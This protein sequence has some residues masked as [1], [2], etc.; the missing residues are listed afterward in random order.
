MSRE[1][2]R[3]AIAA[4]TIPLLVEH[5]SQ[6][7]TRQIALAAGVAEGTLFR[8]FDDKV[9]LLRTAAERALDPQVG[10]REI[11][12]LPQAASLADE[13]AQVARVVLDHGRRARRVMVGLHTL[14]ASDEGRRAERIREARGADVTGRE[15][16]GPAGRAPGTD[17][18]PGGFHPPV[19]HGRGHPAMPGRDA[20]TRA[21]AE[22]KAVVTRRLAAYSGDLRVEPERLAGVLLA[23][24][25]GHGFPFLPEDADAMVADLVEVLLHGAARI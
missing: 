19:P 6:I 7:S 11:E 9:E 21:L 14:L 15:A 10:V 16:R 5:G 4:A 18:A 23:A 25:M 17:G 12:A 8:A 22:E 1:E 13:L 3:D 20:L 24:V 2:R